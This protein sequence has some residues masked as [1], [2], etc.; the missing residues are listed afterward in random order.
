MY[1]CILGGMWTDGEEGVGEGVVAVCVE[2]NLWMGGVVRGGDSWESLGDE[3]TVCGDLYGG[4][5]GGEELMS[6]RW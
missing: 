4:G 6:W 3:W 1:S 5:G 2:V